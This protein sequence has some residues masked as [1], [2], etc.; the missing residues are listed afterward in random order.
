MDKNYI[1]SVIQKYAEERNCCQQHFSP[2]N[3]Y[4]KWAVNEILRSIRES[5]CVLPPI[6]IVEDFIH[7]MDD[8]SCKNNKSSFIFSIAYDV[9]IDVFD[10]LTA[11]KYER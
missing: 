6:M 4:R 9:A 1:L 2:S 11:I 7:K 8:F 10:I 5:E 3:S